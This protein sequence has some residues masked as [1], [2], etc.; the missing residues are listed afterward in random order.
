MSQ[1]M[2]VFKTATLAYIPIWVRLSGMSH[3]KGLLRHFSFQDWFV[4][5]LCSNFVANGS[6]ALP[7]IIFNFHN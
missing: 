4:M 5:Q 2:H 1:F 3:K 7:C 6:K